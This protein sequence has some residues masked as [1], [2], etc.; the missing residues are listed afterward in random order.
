[1]DALP[2]QY[3][4][5][6]YENSFVNDPSLSLQSSSPFPSFAVGDYFNHRTQDVWNKKPETGA[7][8]FRVKE[9]EHIIWSIEGSHIGAKVMVCLEIVSRSL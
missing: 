5:E 8:A 9:V 4:L 6:V 2:L 3:H 1:M 7:E